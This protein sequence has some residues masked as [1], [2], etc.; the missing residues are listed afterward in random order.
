MQSTPEEP[1]CP[2]KA[3]VAAEDRCGPLSI[4]AI[5][6]R[7]QTAVWKADGPRGSVAIKVGYADAAEATL[8][9]AAVLDALPGYTA[10]FD[11]EGN[12]AWLV[13]PWHSG[14]T[15]WQRFD[16]FRQL[17]TGRRHALTAA[18]DLCDSIRD[19]HRG[20]WIHSD[21]QPDH[22]IH[23][24]HGV[25][26]IDWTWA[27]RASFPQHRAFRGGI[28]H[29]LAPELAA[30]ITT[31]TRPVQP[32]SQ[33]EVYTLAACLW[34]CATG[35]WPLDYQAVGINLEDMTAADLRAQIATGTI[36]L[37]ST[38]DWPELQKLLRLHLTPHPADRLPLS[39]L[40][41]ELRRLRRVSLS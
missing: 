33:A 19:L 26:L 17:G 23:T 1:T 22:V 5:T 39:A 8:R 35:N 41:D 10:T 18:I 6:H 28:P 11:T 21:L 13:T 29:L 40:G 14:P 9:E 20:G 37:T 15:T 36:P 32:T 7:R 16:D 34:R 3:L 24:E 2:P 38:T 27:W 4:E 31:G 30:T 12:L 25:R